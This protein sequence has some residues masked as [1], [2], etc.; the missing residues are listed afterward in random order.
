MPCLPW[1]L[2]RPPQLR[3]VRRG[4]T[5][6]PQDDRGRGRK[7]QTQDAHRVVFMAL[8]VLR[9]R[10]VRSSVTG[11]CRYPPGIFQNGAADIGTVQR[12]AGLDTGEQGHRQ[13]QTKT[14]QGP[15][16]PVA[17]TAKVLQHGAIIKVGRSAPENG[18]RA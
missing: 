18:T 17:F 14:H 13:N 15:E 6:G 12:L 11:R 9:W 4:R 7:C 8:V 10:F 3:G 2:W 1:L 5:V 16:G